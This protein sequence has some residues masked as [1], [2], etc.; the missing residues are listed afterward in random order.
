MRDD[1]DGERIDGEEGGDLPVPGEDV[2]AADHERR[3]GEAE[4]E[5]PLEPLQDAAHLRGEVH[6]L[7]FLGRGTP[8]HVDLEEVAQNGLAD[9][10]RET[11]EEDGEH[12]DPFQILKDCDNMLVKP[13]PVLGIGCVCG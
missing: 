13:T 11:A 1:D 8:R 5:R 12:G 3:A 2:E 10:H 6:L 4:Q 7:E 9:V